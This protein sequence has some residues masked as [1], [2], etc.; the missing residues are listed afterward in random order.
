MNIFGFLA[1]PVLPFFLVVTAFGILY[2]GWTPKHGWAVKIKDCI[3][4]PV[5]I[6]ALSLILCGIVGYL[7][8]VAEGQEFIALELF[9]YIVGNGISLS[10]ISIAIYD[11]AHGAIKGVRKATEK[12]EED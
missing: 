10:F 8:G 5:V 9:R 2:K 7:T 11:T 12:K 4:I 3:P 6:T 1:S